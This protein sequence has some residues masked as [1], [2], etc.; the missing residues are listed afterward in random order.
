MDKLKVASNYTQEVTNYGKR[1]NTSG[2]L[3]YN[4]LITFEVDLEYRLVVYD[5]MRI[6]R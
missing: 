4:L 1:L 6:F 5:Q 2:I 3:I